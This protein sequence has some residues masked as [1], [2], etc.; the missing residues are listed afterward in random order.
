MADD[1]APIPSTPAPAS[2]AAEPVSEPPSQ[3]VAAQPAT[4][5]A[6]GKFPT[7]KLAAAL[8]I[9]VLIGWGYNTYSPFWY[10]IPEDLMDVQLGSP[11]EAQQALREKEDEVYYRNGLIH[12]AVLGLGFGLVAIFLGGTQS[13]GKAIA[14][15][16]GV[17]L[18]AGCAAFLIGAKLRSMINQGIEFPVLG[19]L[20]ESMGGDVLVLATVGVVISL[21][22]LVGLIL[23]GGEG[24]AQR[25]M[26]APLAGLVAGL[27]TPIA[28]SFLLPA[29]NSEVFPIRHGGLLAM[30]LVMLALL[31]FIFAL[32]TG[33]RKRK[34]TA[35]LASDQ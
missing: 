1:D 26:S 13:L 34:G 32:T 19:N 17:G 6:P 27:F 25:A 23:F 20:S 3:P 31:V 2:P 28:A 29:Q 22:I 21:P 30:W 9:G 8:I 18:A 4:T 33:D 7:G 16:V 24:A 10:R 14:A 35:D 15:G 12:F 11:P 5:P